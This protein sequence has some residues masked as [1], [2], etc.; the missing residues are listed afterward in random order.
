[1]MDAPP[2]FPTHQTEH[3]AQPLDL[4]SR[5]VDGGGA[6]AFLQPAQGG[7]EAAPAQ[8]P[9]AGGYRLGFFKMKR[10]S[11]GK[12]NPNLTGCHG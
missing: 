11:H 8:A 10:H 1:M 9:H 7:A 3:R 4:L 2:Y 5:R 12:Y 6:I